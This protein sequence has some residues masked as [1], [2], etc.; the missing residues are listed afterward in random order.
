MKLSITIIAALLFPPTFGYA[1]TEDS[2]RADAD[3]VIVV[4]TPKAE[5]AEFF[6]APPAH[7]TSIQMSYSQT[8]L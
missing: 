5:R 6:Y 4:P 2:A 1:Q 7:T 8:P 3:N